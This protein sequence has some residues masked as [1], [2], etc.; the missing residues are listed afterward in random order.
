MK[1]HLHLNLRCPQCNTRLS[2]STNADGA[3]ESPKPGDISIC[4]QCLELLEY[5]TDMTFASVDVTTL[6]PEV[7][8][9]I[10]TALSQAHRFRR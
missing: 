10:L 2:A 1:T 9:L 6:Q 3:T 8:K 5:Q 7:Q 4:A